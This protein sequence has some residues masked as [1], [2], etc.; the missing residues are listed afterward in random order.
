M[1]N[2]RRVTNGAVKAAAG[3]MATVQKATL[4]NLIRGL[5]WFVAV[6][7]GEEDHLSRKTRRGESFFPPRRS[8]LVRSVLGLVKSW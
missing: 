8:P 2:G 3:W 7:R 5:C 6:E 1:V 4:V